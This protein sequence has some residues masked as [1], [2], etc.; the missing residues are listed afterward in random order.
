VINRFWRG[1][2]ESGWVRSGAAPCPSGSAFS[3]VGPGAA[4]PFILKDRHLRYGI[5]I[6]S[7]SQRIRHSVERTRA[8][9]R[10]KGVPVADCTGVSRR[11]FPRPAVRL[12][13]L[14]CARPFLL[15]WD[16]SGAESR[17]L[18]TVRWNSPW[19][20]RPCSRLQLHPLSLQPSPLQLTHQQL[21]ER[22]GTA[23]RHSSSRTSSTSR[24]RRSCSTATHGT[25]RRSALTTIH[26]SFI[27]LHL[28]RIPRPSP[29]RLMTRRCPPPSRPPPSR[30]LLSSLRRPR[31][32]LPLSSPSLP[33]LRRWRS[34][35]MIRCTMVLR[36]RKTSPA[37]SS[38]ESTRCAF[39]ECSLLMSTVGVTSFSALMMP[40]CLLLAFLACADRRCDPASRLGRRVALTRSGKRRDSRRGG[41]GVDPEHDLSTDYLQGVLHPHPRVDD[42]I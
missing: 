8:Q 30:L 41:R 28:H 5:I 4:P 33:L 6:H 19:S 24:A 16:R 10:Q 40:L 32:R 38:V 11:L 1:E 9:R 21:D 27:C 12:A 22:T 3:S 31:L 42:S 7:A 26:R 17:W 37:S 35:P 23:I 18:P 39:A 15:Q 2:S 36:S 34:T 14:R 13:R 20:H 25:R 29:L